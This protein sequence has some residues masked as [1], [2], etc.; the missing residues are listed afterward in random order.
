M[1]YGRIQ[2]LQGT[3]QMAD[4][5][6]SYARADRDIAERLAAA[7][8]ARGWSV[9]WDRRL[10]GG[11]AFDRLIEE[12]IET[13]TAVVVLWSQSSIDSDWVRAEAAF[14]LET[15]KLVPVRIDSGAPPLRYRNIHTPDL[16]PWISQGRPWL[17]DDLFSDLQ[18]KIG[19]SQRRSESEPGSA[20]QSKP[21]VPSD[22]E[23][24]RVIGD[25][26]RRSDFER[27]PVVAKETKIRWA[28]PYR[29]RIGGWVMLVHGAAR[30]ATFVPITVSLIRHGPPFDSEMLLFI[31]AAISFCTAL[32]LVGVGLLLGY[33]TQNRAL[34]YVPSAI[35]R[36][37]ILAEVLGTAL[38]TLTFSSNF[39]PPPDVSFGEKFFVWPSPVLV[40][41]EMVPYA[42]ARSNVI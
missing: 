33:F 23:P 34:Y 26:E 1:L 13:A 27:R 38:L 25:H 4:I 29:M 28:A 22:L 19:A 32:S 35:S 42:F 20:T 8:E 12:A 18:Y 7:L 10:H 15:N 24:A 11:Q 40:L 14:G 37:A 9:W 36:V 31:T 16:T 6:I 17:L 3:D 30:I 21:I 41:L 5:F 39:S 2:T